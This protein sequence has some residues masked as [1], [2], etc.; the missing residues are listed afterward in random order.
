MKYLF[1]ILPQLMSD[2]VII[3]PRW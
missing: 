2:D 3:D 1:V